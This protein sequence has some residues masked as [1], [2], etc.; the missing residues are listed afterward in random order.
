MVAGGAASPFQLE[1]AEG[2]V[3][4]VVTDHDAV[5]ADAMPPGER[6]H[7]R[8]GNV[9]E[10]LWPDQ[11]QSVTVG[12]GFRH[13]HRD[14]PSLSKP[15]TQTLGEV[16]DDAGPD[17]VAGGLVP[18]PWIAQPNNEPGAHRCRIGL[19]LFATGGWLTLGGRSLALGGSALLALGGFLRGRLFLRDLFLELQ[20]RRRHD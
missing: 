18:L 19:P 7:R 3:N 20:N 1:C 12:F 4:L 5:G 9:H 2:Q 17:V 8:P 16:L 6:R 13:S 15:F 14:E 10:R 11:P